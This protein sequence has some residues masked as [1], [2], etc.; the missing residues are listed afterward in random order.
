MRST[1]VFPL[2]AA[3]ALVACDDDGDKDSGPTTPID[4][5]DST[6]PAD[7][8]ESGQPSSLCPDL[9]EP[10]CLDDMIWDLSLQTEVSGG[11]VTT[12]TDGDDFVTVVDAQAGG[13]N[14]ASDNP[15]VYVR[16][17][18]SGASRVDIDDETSLESADWH[19]AARRYLVRLNSGDGGP[20]CVGADAVTGFDYADIGSAP[21]DASY[22]EEDFYDDDCEIIPDSSGLGDASPKFALDGWWEFKKGS[23][24]GCVG[25]TMKP[26]VVQL[27][28][29]EV[30]K[31]V[32]E[33][34]Y[35]EG[36]EDCN[37]NGTTGSDS[38]M[39]TLRWRI[40]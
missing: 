40:L 5:S 21:T 22:E 13:V 32:I 30:I 39:L 34:Y 4:T 18:A 38:A 20:S 7:T 15:W 31:L 9:E 2:L 29:G 10:P 12:V 14:N 6:S 17:D 8:S 19:L 26:F 27:E 37:S 11:D 16:F 24:M 33:T 23:G 28:T 25:T 1:P 3:L 36:Q 35:G